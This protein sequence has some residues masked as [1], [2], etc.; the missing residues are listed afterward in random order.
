MIASANILGVLIYL[1]HKESRSSKAQ[2]GRRKQ[3][4]ARARDTNCYLLR[5]RIIGRGSELQIAILSAAPENPR[6]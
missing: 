1:V 6:W 5:S 2:A 3:Q 4:E